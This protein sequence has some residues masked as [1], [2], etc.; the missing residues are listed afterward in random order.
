[1]T[2]RLPIVNLRLA[3]AL[4]SLAATCYAQTATV[5]GRV[6]DSTE[7]VIPGTQITVTNEATA[8][9]REAEAN[10]AGYYT[11]PLL[12][13]GQYRMIV[14]MGRIQTDYPRWHQ[15]RGRPDC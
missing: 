7:S 3:V 10:Q 4:L 1:M 5:T 15:P 2:T 8:A 13:P 11:V 12:P 6:T 9:V 14:E